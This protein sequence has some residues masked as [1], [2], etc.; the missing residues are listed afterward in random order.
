MPLYFAYGSNMDAAA[1][2]ARCPDSRPLG[3]ARLDRHRFL[4]MRAGY[5]SVRPDPAG[6]VW[7]LLWDLAAADE[8]ALDRYE[9]VDAGLYDKAWR[10]VTAEAGMVRAL[11]YVGR[12]AEP[13]TPQPGYG[14]AVLAAAE[15]AGV[16]AAYL[17]ELRGRLAGAPA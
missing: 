9:E 13:G 16:P 5:A 15:A 10:T 11:V 3:L 4:V 7:G 6:A 1:M 2:A 12:D 8:P 14:V 17:E